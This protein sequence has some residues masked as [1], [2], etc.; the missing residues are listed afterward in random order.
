MKTRTA[1][2]SQFL[3]WTIRAVLI[4]LIFSVPAWGRSYHIAKFNSN[5]HLDEDGSARVE[6]QI[7]FAFVGSFQ[8][9]YRSIPV[10]Y[11]GPNGSNYSLFLKVA[12]VTDEN[13]SALKYE[14][15]TKGAYLK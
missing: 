7:S 10:E 8:G 12:R 6:E 2:K 9:V 14:K 1:L 13:G 5:V 4:L 15:H 11:P 3:L